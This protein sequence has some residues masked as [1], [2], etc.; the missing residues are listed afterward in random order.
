[1]PSS[2][3]TYDEW[4]D[5]IAQQMHH[6]RFGRN[7]A[8][9][10]ESERERKRRVAREK[11]A[12]EEAEREAKR[13]DVREKEAQETVKKARGVWAQKWRVLKEAKPGCEVLKKGDL[14]IPVVPKASALIDKDAV[15]EFLLS[16]IDSI[17][18]KRKV[19]KESLLLYHPDKFG[20][21]HKAKFVES[22]W[23]AVM[24]LTGQIASALNDLN[25]SLR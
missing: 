14:P 1:T 6:K 5:S 24:E 2:R 20:A 18:A 22:S 9:E 10:A 16:G 23:T 13:R 25:T 11:V 8:A 7:R 15:A 4:A 3:S 17:D 19:V 12:K 21:V